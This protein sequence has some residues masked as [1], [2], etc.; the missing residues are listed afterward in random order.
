M[1]PA[2]RAEV[3]K[4]LTVRSTYV[5]T[6]LALALAGFLAFYVAGIKADAAS[7]TDPNFLRGVARGVEGVMGF[8]VG[9]VAILLVV[10]EYR[11]NTIMHTLTAARSRM[12]VFAAKIIVLSAF[13][14][15]AATLVLLVAVSF[16]TLGLMTRGM[17]LGTQHF[18]I[19]D[20]LL[21]G[22]F[23]CWGWA[24]IGFILAIIIRSTA[25]AVTFL[26][27]GPALLEQLLSLVLKENVAYLP[28]NILNQIVG[29][30][31]VTFGLTKTVSLFVLY[32]FIGWAVSLA[33]FTRRDAN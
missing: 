18:D 12:D 3:R 21:R 5:I 28:F 25:G 11:Y 13:A 17:S 4:L 8:F 2:I 1:M 24:M 9:L 20:A 14:A 10:H 32:V 15:V 31:R 33:L 19:V 7:V 26:F 22:V 27:I 23:F 6:G 30:G 16:P 29:E